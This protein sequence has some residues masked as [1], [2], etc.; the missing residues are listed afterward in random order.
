[1]QIPIKYVYIC[2]HVCKYTYIDID[3]YVYLFIYIC[4]PK[5]PGEEMQNY[6]QEVPFS[7]PGG[8]RK[9]K[10]GNKQKHHNR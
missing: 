9:K 8:W 4:I 1:M 10:G 3:K 2:M 5:K 7:V 6:P